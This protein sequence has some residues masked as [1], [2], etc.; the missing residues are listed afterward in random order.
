MRHVQV[1]ASEHAAV[2]YVQEVVALIVQLLA[3]PLVEIVQVSVPHNVEILVL[4]VAG[5]IALPLVVKLALVDV[6]VVAVDVL[7]ALDAERCVQVD[8]ALFVQ[9]VALDVVA[10]V[11][12]DVQQIV[13]L[14]VLQ[15]V[16]LNVRLDVEGLVL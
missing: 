3:E 9:E 10:D 12:Q 11:V 5:A 4:I 7:D 13:L 16:T 1:Y 8:V 2:P 14:L 6:L 15:D